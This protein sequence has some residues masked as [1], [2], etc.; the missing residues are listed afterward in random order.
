MTKQSRG[1]REMF[2]KLFQ[3]KR[4]KVLE[5]LGKQKQE[6]IRTLPKQRQKDREVTQIEEDQKTI[7][8]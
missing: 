5:T 2:M 6:Y 1:D 8:Q 7:V 4:Q 3:Q